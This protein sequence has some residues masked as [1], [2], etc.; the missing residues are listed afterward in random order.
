MTVTAVL[1]V[2]GQHVGLLLVQERG[3]LLGG[4][5][6]RRGPERARRLVGR[7]AHHARV[8]VPEELH[9]LRAKDLRGCVRGSGAS[10]SSGGYLRETDDSLGDLDDHPF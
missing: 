7:G 4:L 6:D 10:S 9:P 5:V 8:D 2:A 1:V 3:E